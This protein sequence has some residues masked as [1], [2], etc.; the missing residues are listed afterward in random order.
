[1]NNSEIL[2]RLNEVI[3]RDA[4]TPSRADFLAS[5]T[6]FRNIKFTKSGRSADQTEYITEDQLSSYL[7]ESDIEEHRFIIVQGINGSGKSHLIRWLKEK[8]DAEYKRDE[9]VILFISRQQ[10][11]LKG[12]IEQLLASDIFPET[13]KNTELKKLFKASE[14]LDDK[15]LKK[16][17]INQFGLLTE[18]DKSDDET[19]LKNRFK[20]ISEIILIE[21]LGVIL[22]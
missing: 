18:N 2:N 17:I 3:R 7:F 19:F 4:T 16:N 9:D 20:N 22:G 6:P 12:A 1:M 14:A 15:L 10:S 13:W 5:H 11:T 8:Y 21:N